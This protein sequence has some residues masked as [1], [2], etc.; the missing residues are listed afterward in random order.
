[1]RSS[2]WRF[3][4][5][6]LLISSLRSRILNSPRP[7]E[8]QVIKYKLVILPTWCHSN[9]TFILI[10]PSGALKTI[11]LLFHWFLQGSTTS[12]KNGLAKASKQTPLKNL[13]CQRLTEDCYP[14]KLTSWWDHCCHG[15]SVFKS[16][17]GWQRL[18]SK[19]TLTILNLGNFFSNFSYDLLNRPETRVREH[20]ATQ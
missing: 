10:C 1:M 4:L 5:R 8:K 13:L 3:S 9:W 19:E 16:L 12:N 7:A 17:C 18:L 20:F 14:P 2:Q 6:S 15:L 11:S